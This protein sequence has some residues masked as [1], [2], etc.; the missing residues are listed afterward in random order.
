MYRFDI[1]FDYTAWLAARPAASY[2][3]MVVTADAGVTVASSAYSNGKV[4]VTI[5]GGTDGQSYKVT[6]RVTTTGLV[7]VKESEC[8]L[9]VKEV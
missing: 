4:T 2:G 1:I 8:I 5:S 7:L 9:N 3:S 6:C